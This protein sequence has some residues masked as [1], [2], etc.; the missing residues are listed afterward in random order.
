MVIP[1][2]EIILFLNVSTTLK[3]S[4]DD[5]F[6]VV[7]TLRNKMISIFGITIV[8]YFIKIFSGSHNYW[9]SVVI[10]SNVML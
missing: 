5:D 3:S 4:S 10:H 1:N 9:C 7:E 8:L 2:I 6:K